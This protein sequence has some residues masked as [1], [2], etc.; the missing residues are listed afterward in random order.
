LPET[1]ANADTTVGINT[2]ENFQF[3]VYPQPAKDLLNIELT[4]ANSQ[5]TLQLIDISGKLICNKDL[6]SNN[7]IT[8]NLATKKYARGVYSLKFQSFQFNRIQKVILN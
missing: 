7:D 3:S 1:S 6:N 4:G 2:N 8:I 5:S